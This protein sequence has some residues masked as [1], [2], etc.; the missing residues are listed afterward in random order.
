MKTW[1]K[2]L[3]AVFSILLLAGITLGVVW[4]VDNWSA[5]TS[6]TTLYTQEDLDNAYNKGLNDA[7][8]DVII[9]YQEQ[10]AGLQTELQNKEITIGNLTDQL[11]DALEN[12]GLKD[13]EIE[14]LKK[15]IDD[16]K[17]DISAKQEQIEELQDDIKYYEELLEAYG[18]SD[19]LRV[20]FTMVDNGK[21][22][23]Y[24]V[25]VVEPNSYLTAVVTPDRA[26]FEGWSLSKGGELIDDLTTIQVT[27][28][29][30]IYGMCTNTVTFMVNGEEYAT[31]EV[32]YNESLTTSKISVPRYVFYGWDF[33]NEPIIKDTTI[34][35]IVKE[36][37]FEPTTFNNCENIYGRNIWTDGENIYY[38]NF[39]NDYYVLDKETNTWDEKTWNINGIYAEYIWNAEENTFFND[40][41]KSYK[42]NI[43]LGEWEEVEWHYLIGGTPIPYNFYG[44][45]VRKIN[46]NYYYLSNKSVF[47]LDTQNLTLKKVSSDDISS[48]FPGGSF[49]SSYWTDGVNLYHSNGTSNQYIYNFELGI[50]EETN[51]NI[52]VNGQYVWNCGQN[53]YYSNGNEQYILDVDT[54]NW[55][56]NEWTGIIGL[57]RDKVWTDGTNI[58]YANGSEQYVLV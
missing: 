55:I 37:K 24:D 11:N 38:S 36:C 2:W 56:E 33:N 22:R 14:G 57:Q 21:E 8:Y 48:S 43:E 47:L 18:D 4:M 32:S 58:Y 23:N 30:T 34:N 6:N 31:Q 27:E 29:M 15:E 45:A 3:I 52:L 44:N 20:T 42:L 10:I 51:W 39:D 16:L 25:Q 7:G 26:D 5:I 53:T 9:Q 28:N 19:K 1:K 17:T 12:G 49:A 54:R 35:A 41:N 46:G 13:D 40:A 50:W